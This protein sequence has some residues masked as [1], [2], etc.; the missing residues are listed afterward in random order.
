MAFGMCKDCNWWDPKD[1]VE[2]DN[3]GVC[4]KVG[5]PLTDG[6]GSGWFSGP[7]YIGPGD[8]ELITRSDFG[9]SEFEEKG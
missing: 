5:V 8:A 4:Y 6:E 9:C 2:S 7:F 1:V 3:H